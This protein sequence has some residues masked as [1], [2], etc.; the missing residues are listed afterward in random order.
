MRT[1]HPPTK[2]GDDAWK[3]DFPP[4]TRA[5]RRETPPVEAA[6]ENNPRGRPEE[7]AGAGG[8][9]FY[10]S[11]AFG[12]PAHARR[13]TL[14]LTTLVRI[15]DC[16]HERFATWTTQEVLAPAIDADVLCRAHL[17]AHEWLADLIQHA[18][19]QDR[20][21]QIAFS[22]W[23]DGNRLR[24]LIADN[25]EGLDHID[26][27]PGL[28]PAECEAMPEPVMRWLFIRA[29]TDRVAYRPF[30]NQGYGLEF[31]IG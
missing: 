11:M 13:E 16:L 26:Q 24:C 9:I 27:E 10:A 20:L 23:T 15:I 28:L 25:S 19:F 21:P 31:S 1:P 29:C 22:V 30:G 5:A 17:A 7:Q 2:H 14:P 8:G 18:D 4:T 6:I 12:N 3:Q